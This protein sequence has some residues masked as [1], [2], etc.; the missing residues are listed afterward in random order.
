MVLQL[1]TNQPTERSWGFKSLYLRHNKG[2]IMEK[3]VRSF[4]EKEIKNLG[5][6]TEL[7]DNTNLT[8]DCGFDSLDFVEIMLHVEQEYDIRIPDE[9]AINMKTYGDAVKLV[10]K[11]VKG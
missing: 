7:T 8:S 3:Q 2:Y 11:Y 1:I 6:N 10:M 5:Y 9:E 4:I